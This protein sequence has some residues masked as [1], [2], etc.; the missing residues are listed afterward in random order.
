MSDHTP[1]YAGIILAAG[2]SRRMGRDK[3]QLPW[4]DGLL[5]LP[6]LVKALRESGWAPVVVLG[7]HNYDRWVHELPG[8]IVQL[9]EAPERGKTTSLALG[10]DAV[11]ASARHIMVSAVDQPR[12]PELYGRLHRAAEERPEMVIMPDEKGHRG[13]P[14]VLKGELRESFQRLTEGASGL[15]GLL[16]KYLSST[17]RM[18]CPAEWMGWDCNT[19]EAYQ[20]ALSWFE[21][22]PT[23]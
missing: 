7:P 2:V 13:H 20:A 11:P 3:T 17:Y 19:P 18:P 5:L 23:A 12:L 21:S 8:A 1:E 6:W 16:N 14:V 10:L 22:Q 4:L 15:R 9:N